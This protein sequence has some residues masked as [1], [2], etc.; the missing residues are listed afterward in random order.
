MR[1]T[2]DQQK[3]L[4][5]TS[6]VPPDAPSVPPV[7][8]GW[9]ESLR[10]IYPPLLTV[11]EYCRLRNRCPA[12]AYNDFRK[13]PGLA[14]KDGRATRVVT[15]VALDLIGALPA[16]V[17]EQDRVAEKDR[18]Y[19]RSRSRTETASG[20]SDPRPN[21]T[22]AAPAPHREAPGRRATAPGTTSTGGAGVTTS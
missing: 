7:A 22:G 10:K 18:P 13:H 3:R 14:V 19:E 5:E 2:L 8:S 9:I 21:R 1:E 17:P 4:A 15:S 16:W 12:S 11:S 6:S 20:S